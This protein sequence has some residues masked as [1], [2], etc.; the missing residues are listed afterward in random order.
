MTAAKFT[1]STDTTTEFVSL[2]SFRTAYATV[3]TIHQ[4]YEEDNTI[5]RYQ[6][7]PDFQFY[8]AII[9]VLKECQ[10]SFLDYM[11]LSIS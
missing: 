3:S 5:F 2:H 8:T 4:R 10:L 1:Y 9:I 6:N 7:R 11:A